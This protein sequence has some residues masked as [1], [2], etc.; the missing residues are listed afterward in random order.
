MIKRI[1]AA[2]GAIVF[3]VAAGTSLSYAYWV[4]SAA[5]TATVAA[6]NPTVT[7]CSSIVALQNGGFETASPALADNSWTHASTLANW[8]SQVPGTTTA[9]ASEVW[10]GT[11]VS[12]ILPASG[13]QN[14]E[15]NSTDATTLYQEVATVPGQVLR[16][17]F[18]HRGR[19]SAAVGDKVKLT[20]GAPTVNAA[21]TST[22]TSTSPILA[23]I[24]TTTN[25]AWVYYSGTYSV[26]AGQTTTRL[27]LTSISAGGSNISQANLIDDVS[28]GTGPCVTASSTIANV[29]TGG[30]TYRVGD[31]V[32]YVTTISN[33][34][35]ASAA[36]AVAKIVLPA[37]LT[38]VSGS[39]NIGAATQTN[40]AGDDLAE[41]VSGSRQIVARVGAGASTTVGGRVANGTPVTV[42]YDAVIGV[43]AAGGTITHTPSVEFIDEAIP[44][45]TLSVTGT[46]LSSA[47][48]AAAD[49]S[50]AVLGQPTITANGAATWSF[51]VTNNGPSTAAGGSV[52]L[53]LT[54]GPTYGTPTYTTS[55]AGPGTA[56]CTGAGTSRTCAIGTIPSGE[57]R[58]ITV[59]ATLPASPS[60]FYPVTATAS[61]TTHDHVSANNAATSTGVDGV[62]PNAPTGVTAA[63]AS[64]T[65][66]TVGWT[67]ATDPVGT[68]AGYLL[69]R[70]GTLVNS[71]GTLITSTSYTHTVTTNSLNWYWVV[72]VDTAGNVSPSSSGA[73]AAAYVTGTT[74]VRL[75][76]PGGTNLCLGASSTFSGADVEIRT[77]CTSVGSSNV[78]WGFISSPTTNSAQIQLG[79]SNLRWTRRDLRRHQPDER[80][81]PLEA[82]RAVGRQCAVPAFHVRR[83]YRLLRDRQRHHQWHRPP[84][85]DVQYVA[86]HPAVHLGGLVMRRIARAIIALAALA[87]AGPMIL[88]AAPAHAAPPE[89]LVSTDGVTFV[90]A[91][92]VDIFD[93]LDL[94]VP[95]NTTAG[96]LWVRNDST[97][98]A[99]VRVAVTDLLVSSPAYGAALT[100]SSAMNG[101]T[102]AATFAT[103][104]N[105]QVVVQA[106]T[107]A[108]G[109]TTR[110]D[111]GVTMSSATNGR[112]AQGE[113]ADIGFMVT[114]HD[115]AAGPFPDANGCSSAAAGPSPDPS[116]AVTGSE[117]L[118]TV[119]VAIGLLVVGV[120]FT[121]L[122]RRRLDDD[123]RQS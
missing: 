99:L 19:D 13:A 20:V 98:A 54:S 97:T 107:L 113:A 57:G 91:T 84:D 119:F 115:S 112:T 22:T 25:S 68:V 58:T 121:M 67:A 16:W 61:A 78:Q 70:N 66:I 62:A 42:T 77:G 108:A 5:M 48:A 27:S 14:I 49:L 69:Y 7:N 10:R 56:N 39:I 109:A 83:R 43:G 32:R 9:R 2:L 11:V 60:S 93:D 21:D 34:G 53:A 38:I 75:I 81:R 74:N 6:A 111:L 45:W 102:F 123:T 44:T 52:A 15:L 30:G 37:N 36:S 120:L 29:T 26:P 86:D 90:P 46:T 47:V 80:R 35:G 94:I 100:L 40:A 82:R 28:L 24:F 41:Y 103:L 96:Q 73:G 8:T 71:L 31:T 101:A 55:N 92:S 1:A 33:G 12:P 110:V 4:S 65:T 117:V 72:A 88:P 18:W 118:P 106:Q 89:I 64:S 87:L 59:T 17:S 104:S 79:S 3:L 95:G 63:R 85:G 116:L 76:Y 51:R 114:A 50:V 122:R 23:Q 105:C